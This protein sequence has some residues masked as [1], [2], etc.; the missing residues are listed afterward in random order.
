M[1]KQT[2]ATTGSARK[3]RRTRRAQSRRRKFKPGQP[4]GIL[5]IDPSAPASVLDVLA[6]DAEHVEESRPGDA[7]GLADLQL[8]DGVC[9]VNVV[10]LGTES[11]LREVAETF[12]I[13]P[14][15]MEDIVNLHQRPK[16]E[17]YGDHLFVV[18]RLPHAGEVLTVEQISVYAGP[19]FVVTFQEYEGDC[20]E[21]VRERIRK[22]RGRIRGLG[23]DYLMYG[24]VDA[25]ADHY[26]PLL[27]LYGD[28]LD[29]LEDEILA[30]SSS[31]VMQRL[32]E[33]KRDL[34]RLRRS[35][36]PLRDALR[37]L[38]TGGHE[39]VTEDTRLYLRDCYDHLVVAVDMLDNHREV[40][41]NLVNVHL[42]VVS[43]RMNEIMKVLTIIATVFMPLGFVAGLYGM[44]FD[45]EASPWNMPELAWS[46]GY[47][48][49]LG[50]MA[51]ISA[52]LMW[53][54]YRKGWLSRD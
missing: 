29:A 25:V 28:K 11:M 53:F 12:A 16:V 1:T 50:V 17:E 47:P 37:L 26:F 31:S 35:V 20:F 15:A 19:G 24:L 48:F 39:F 54:F 14:L 30:G 49:A 34:M 52:L 33:V 42:S 40:D 2:A 23:A 51:T 8:D 22:Q 6:Y 27:E 38:L 43:Q 18:L 4:P 21:A 46:Y 45:R 9:W 44:N 13:H 10:G 5:R 36:W 7:S 32:L 3:A 41:S